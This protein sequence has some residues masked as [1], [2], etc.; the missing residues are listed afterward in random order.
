MNV[1][2]RTEALETSGSSA[3]SLQS[4]ERLQPVYILPFDDLL[5][6]VII[7]CLK[8]ARGYDCLIGFFHSSSLREMAPGL[9]EFLQRPEAKMRLL[10]SPYLAA[11][12]HRAIEEGLTN[13][14]ELLAKR[15]EE[16]YGVVSIDQNALTRHALECLAY[17]IATDRIEIKVVVV[18]NGLFHPKI[19]IFADGENV[20]VVHG[21]NNLTQPGL[22]TNYEQVVVSPSWVS[23]EQGVITERLCREFQKIW[24]STIS[25][26]FRVYELPEALKSRI[27]RGFLPDKPPTPESF[28]EAWKA[29][30]SSAPD[31]SELGKEPGKTRTDEVLKQRFAI[32][33][34]LN[35]EEGDF[36]H[37][38][39]AVAAWEAAGRC[40]ILEMATGSGKTVMAL[41]AAQHA[42]AEAGR[43]LLVVAAPYLPLISQWADEARRFGLAPVVPGEAGSKVA[44]L[45]KIQQAVRNLRLGLETVQCLVVTHDLLCDQE[46]AESL[47]RFK[48]PSM[49]I[50]DEVHNLGTKRFLSSPPESFSYRLGLS[51][52]PVRQY[53]EAGT[54]G[55]LDFFGEIV[56]RFT[57]ED[58]IGRCLVPYDYYLHPVSLTEDELAEWL[59]LTD[60]LRALG[61]QFAG[62][63]SAERLPAPLQRLLNKRRLI[64]EQAEGKVAQLRELLRSS[65]KEIK[66]TLV[67]VSDKGRRQLTEVNRLLMDELGIRVHQLTQEETARRRLAEG[68]LESFRRGEAIQVLTAMRVLDEGVD[69][70]EVSKA[71]ILAS[72]TVERQWVQR[73]GRVLRKCPAINKSSAEIHDFLVIPP[74][75]IS[76]AAFGPDVVAL[77]KGEL[78]RAMEFARTARNAGTPDGALATIKPIVERYFR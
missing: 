3:K 17:M 6:E 27:V 55:L 30:T 10:I 54:Q 78:A 70:P 40:G 32:P 57:L 52:T 43:L 34:G 73:R 21:S 20:V 19:R 45:S 36:A 66:H 35:Y 60:K 31:S 68:L 26:H 76:P 12:D 15:L 33:V 61:W 37:Q 24:N 7:P 16:L 77:L 75:H 56:F 51:A 28:W 49:L 25:N 8:L 18:R 72:T 1:G 53:D 13:P 4:L 23:K 74:E 62:E 50:A 9:A 71:Y 22:T 46:F 38:G 11:E 47:G 59:E 58:A 44:K 48:G 29:V 67:Y 14:A 65:P 5:G 63:E 42:W 2:Q 69:I 39:K 41:L 64:L